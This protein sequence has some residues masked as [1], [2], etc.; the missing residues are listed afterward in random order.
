MSEKGRS[1]PRTILILVVICGLGVG[2]YSLVRTSFPEYF[3]DTTVYSVAY[4]KPKGWKEEVP[5]PFTLFVFRHPEGKGLIR[6]SLNEVQ[7]RTNPTPELDTDGIAKHYVDVTHSN[8]PEWKAERLPD[9]A[10]GTERFSLIL[11]TKKDR[12]VYTA[13]CSKGNSTLVVSLTAGGVN[14]STLAALVPAF[15][16]VIESVKLTPKF[17]QIDD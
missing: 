7:S 12:T 9:L 1:W 16:K 13:F 5:G 14:A 8:M 3:A 4:E 15:R 10:N 11:R 6:A 17:V 2:A